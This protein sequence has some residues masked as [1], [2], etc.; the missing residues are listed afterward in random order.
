[1]SDF[2]R[3]RNRRLHEL[4]LKVRGYMRCAVIARAWETNNG[5][6]YVRYSMGVKA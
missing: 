2:L 5:K 4:A 1:M 6:R 3:E